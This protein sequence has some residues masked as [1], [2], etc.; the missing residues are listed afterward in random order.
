[1]LEQFFR[2]QILCEKQTYAPE[3]ERI[4]PP[5]VSRVL[6]A[7]QKDQAPCLFKEKYR[8]LIFQ[9][10]QASFYDSIAQQNLE[11]TYLQIS[12]GKPIQQSEALKTKLW[13]QNTSP[14]AA[15][16]TMSF[17]THQSKINKI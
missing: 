16:A 9:N 14:A 8:K 3:N 7:F 11:R 4:C 17:S 12:T 5:R 13:I 1:M 2:P 10:F 15:A 6:P